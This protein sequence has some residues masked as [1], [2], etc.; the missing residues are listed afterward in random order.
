VYYGLAQGDLKQIDCDFGDV[1]GKG[2]RGFQKDHGLEETGVVD[3][4]TLENLRKVFESKWGDCSKFF[5]GCKDNIQTMV[6]WEPSGTP[7]QER[8]LAELKKHVQIM[9]GKYTTEDYTYISE[10]VSIPDYSESEI[11]AESGN[12]FLRIGLK[13]N[14]LL[15]VIREDLDKRERLIMRISGNITKEYP[16]RYMEIYKAAAETLGR[17]G[18][19]DC[20]K[21]IPGD[22]INRLHEEMVSGFVINAEVFDK[23]DSPCQLIVKVS[24][25]DTSKTFPV[26]N[27]KEASFEHVNFEFLVKTT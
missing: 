24:V 22:K 19:V 26:F 16:L 5:E 3:E 6:F 4:Q 14:D 23:E 8:I 11:S 27:G 15:T 18:N 25:K 7:N 2:L 1:T 20:S 10:Q 12:G 13:S 21:S 9:M 17:I